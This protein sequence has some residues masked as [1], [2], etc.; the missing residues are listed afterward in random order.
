MIIDGVFIKYLIEELNQNLKR[1]RLEKVFLSN[2]TTFVMQFY[3]KGLRRNL[4][5]DLN[6]NS[7]GAYISDKNVS[8]SVTSQ[9]LLTLKK[10]LE[11]G[12]LDSIDQYLTDR[13]MIFKFIVFDFIDGPVE[14]S[15][16]FEAMGK[17]SNLILVKDENLVDTYKKMF[18][19][20]GRQLIPGAKFEFF[21]TDKKTFDVIDYTLM[22][23]PK[24]ISASYMGIS[25]K[26]ASYLFEKQLQVN[27][28][29]VNPTKSITKNTG[30]CIDIFSKSDEKKYYPSLSNLLDD[31]EEIDVQF[32]Q[33]LESYIDKYLKKL[34]KKKD[35]LEQHYNLTQQLLQKRAE[36]DMI[37]SSGLNLSQSQSSL[38]HMG[39]VIILD[40]MLSLNEN[41][42][43]FYK[44]YQKAKRGLIH[45]VEQLEQN[46]HLIDLFISYKTYL[47]IAEILDIT[48]LENDLV[49]YGYKIKNKNEKKKN[50]YIPNIIKISDQNAIYLIGKNDKQNEYVT[51]ELARSND[52][53]FHVKDAPGSHLI[54]KCEVLNE[55]ILRK[56]AMLAAHF[57]SLSMS[58][59][60]P[61][62]YT[63]VKNLK[64]I[65]KLPG[66][67]VIIKNQKTMYIDIDTETLKSY[68]K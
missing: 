3:T 17:H 42:Q 58:S 38:N 67:K 26:L 40:P 16:I 52:Y 6:P 36:A 46:S 21:P 45:I 50:K 54:V 5:I 44:V 24:M 56:A 33:S 49:P 30:Y 2:D 4:V 68:L 31:Q 28:L 60:I 55:Q 34:Y 25:L 41:A 43:K 65:P 13:V 37:Y 15:L 53:F 63:L 12:I 23:S 59:S 19:E 22:E 64:K 11:G 32:K 10:Q 14:K 18:F 47:D 61:V 9:F 66:Y 29:V 39:Q 27:N 48:D 51:H 62:D 1:A 57:S 35:D 8:A 20:A 7:F